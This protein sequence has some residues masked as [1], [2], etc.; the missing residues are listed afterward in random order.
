MYHSKEL[1]FTFKMELPSLRCTVSFN[2]CSIL[3][4]AYSIRLTCYRVIEIYF[5]LNLSLSSRA[6]L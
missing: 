5:F 2:S 4:N 1:S 3:Y 6:S